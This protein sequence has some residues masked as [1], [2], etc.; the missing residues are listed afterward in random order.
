MAAELGVSL[1]RSE[2]ARAVGSAVSM[3]LLLERT[4]EHWSPAI[5]VFED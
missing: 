3:S 4:H 2:G 1:R 5:A